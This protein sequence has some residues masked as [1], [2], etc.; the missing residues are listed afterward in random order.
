[1]DQ[2]GNSALIVAVCYNNVECFKL[3]LT[4]GTDINIRNNVCI[5]KIGV[6]IYIYI[7]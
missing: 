5:A 1:M 4:A 7:I 2:D 6:G 3:L